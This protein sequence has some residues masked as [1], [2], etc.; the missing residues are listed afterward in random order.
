MAR[1]HTLCDI[2]PFPGSRWLCWYHPPGQARACL[3]RVLC[4]AD[5]YAEAL[6]AGQQVARRLG[7]PE[8]PWCLPLR[9]D[10]KPQEGA[11]FSCTPRA[12]VIPN[13]GL[14]RVEEVYALLPPDQWL[15]AKAIARLLDPERKYKWLHKGGALRPLRL[16]VRQGRVEERQQGTQAEFRRKA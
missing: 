2:A 8:S 15:S 16:L 13:A 4:G 5:T 3:W 10:R 6:E 1:P 14:Q 12:P 9:R 11:G 7:L